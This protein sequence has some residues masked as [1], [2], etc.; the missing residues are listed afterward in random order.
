MEFIT[1]GDTSIEAPNVMRAMAKLKSKDRM[2]GLTGYE[3]E[4]KV[5]FLLLTYFI[6][7]C[8]HRYWKKSVPKLKTWCVLLP[9]HLLIKIVQAIVSP[10]L[11]TLYVVWYSLICLYI[12]VERCRVPLKQSY[13]NASYA[14]VRHIHYVS[15]IDC[16]IQGYKQSRA[17]I[18]A[19]SPMANTITDF[20]KMISGKQCAVIIMLCELLENDEVSKLNC[21]GNS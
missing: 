17:Y 21:I 12:L 2:T 15:V 14:D 8:T 19:Q 20:W 11:K 6:L 16:A 10:V 7:M 5:T 18:I 1:C 13:I 4:L 9:I 3:Q